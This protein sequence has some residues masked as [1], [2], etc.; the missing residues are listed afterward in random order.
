MTGRRRKTY[1]LTKKGR[2]ALVDWLAGPTTA[3]T[4]LRDPDLLKLYFGADP[5]AVAAEQAELHR[6]KLAEYE[7]F[8]AHGSPEWKA[9]EAFPVYVKH[10]GPPL[11]LARVD[12]RVPSRTSAVTTVESAVVPGFEAA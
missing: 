11:V 4:E 2:K 8:I 1:A 6:R 10:L 7:T 5:Q 9:G 12:D 3:F